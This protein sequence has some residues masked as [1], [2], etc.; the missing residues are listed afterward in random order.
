MVRVSVDIEAP[1][2]A[3]E[4]EVSLIVVAITKPFAE[5]NDSAAALASPIESAVRFD[6]S[7][8]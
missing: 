8:L 4:G 2:A 1:V 6:E 5:A 7:P 3:A